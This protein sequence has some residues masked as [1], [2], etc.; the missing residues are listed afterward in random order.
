MSK[1][2]GVKEEELEMEVRGQPEGTLGRPEGFLLRMIK[3]V[4]Y[5]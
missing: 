2:E 5:F 4:R 1:A 3:T